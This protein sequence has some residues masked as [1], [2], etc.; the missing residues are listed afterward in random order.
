MNV[1]VGR[2]DRIGD[3]AFSRSVLAH[4]QQL[5]LGVENGFR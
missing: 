3:V 1:L 4:W 5:T 2:V